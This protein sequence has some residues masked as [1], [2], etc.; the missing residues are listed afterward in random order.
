[1]SGW[2]SLHR[3][4]LTHELFTERRTFSRFEA[5][6]HLLITAE[7][8]DKTVFFYNADYFVRRGSLI[9]SKKKLSQEW[10]W[11]WDKVNTFISYLVNNQMV[12]IETAKPIGKNNTDRDT[13]RDT[14]AKKPSYFPSYL[15]ICKYDTYQL[16]PSYL[17]GHFDKK[18]V[19]L[20]ET[21]DDLHHI[22]A[23]NN[24]SLNNNINNTFLPTSEINFFSLKE[25][26]EE[27]FFKIISKDKPELSQYADQIVENYLNNRIESGFVN[28]KN[29][30]ITN[31][32]M[33]FTNWVKFEF[34]NKYTGASHEPKHSGTGGKTK[35]PAESK[36]TAEQFLA[37]IRERKS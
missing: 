23:Y 12:T 28:K 13:F 30:K 3:K 29:K 6:L 5:W 1:M 31:I 21:L 11:S 10:N 2:I 26:Y 4:V 19:I 27:I 37:K 18:T 16:S 35:K 9:T 20:S 15:T 34:I 17:S 32:P 36:T 24:A 8:A 7:F 33:D 22:K 25:K 14:L